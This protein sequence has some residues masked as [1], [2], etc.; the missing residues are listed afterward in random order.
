M[1]AALPPLPATRALPAP[2]RRRRRLRAFSVL[3]LLF[4][5]LVYGASLGAAALYHVVVTV[6][7]ELPA[8]LSQ[9]LQYEPNR[10][11]VVLSSDGEEI[12]AFSIENRRMV[13]L[14]RMPPH[15]VAAFISAEDGRFF[16]HKG[17]DLMGIGRA[18]VRNFRE[19]GAIRQGGSTIT[20]QII[21]QTLLAA[22]E[23]IGD[24]DLTDEE[25]AHLAKL[26][27]YRRKMKEVILAVR[28]E[29]ELTKAEILSI[30]LN[31]I[32][33]GNGAYGVGAAART[34]FGKEIEDVTVAEAAMLAGLVASPSKYAPHRNMELAR[35]RQRYVLGRLR[36]DQYISDAELEAALAEPIALVGES[37]LNHLA[38]PYFVEHI[39]KTATARYGNRDLFKGGL[40]F[41]STLDTRVQAAA[42][43]ALRRGLES[44]E[45]R[46]G[47]RG[48]IGSVPADKRGA[49]TDGPAHP[50][51]GPS[52]DTTALADRVLP[53][54]TY[55]AMVVELPR[56]GAGV[57]VD[58]GPQRLPLAEA[59]AREVRAWR[60]APPKPPAGRPPWYVPPGWTPQTIRLGDLLPVRLA[61]GG[62]AAVLAQ[63]PQLQGG[64]VVLEPS[65]GR[66]L[67]MVGGYDWTESQFD[68]VTQARRQVGSSIKPFIYAAALEAG[69]T[70]VDRMHDGPY[71]VTTATGVW[72]PANYADRYMGSVTLMTA[73]A[74]SLNT[75][76]V[77]LSVQVGIDRLIEI[78]R[79]FGVRSQIP[80]HISI[81]LGTP[82]LTPLEIA[83]GYAGIA[84]GGRRVTP[85][86]F[87]LVTTTGGNVVEDLR[88]APPGPQVLSPEVAYVTT[89]MMKGVISR[90][91][92]RFATQLGRPIAGKTGTSANYR[93]V[94]F[95]GYT[96]DLL[97]TVWV[98]RDDSTPIGD[99]ITGGGIAVPIWLELMQKAH[100][101]TP[102]RDFPVPPNVSFARVEPWSGEVAP[103]WLDA[104]WM[105]FVR[106]TFPRSFLAAPPVRSF[107][108]LWL[109]PTPPP[110]PGAAR[111]T[112]LRCL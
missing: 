100:P 17:F 61:E 31:H 44:L 55:G 78:L 20:Q 10:K 107:D 58:L 97:A 11:S 108:E 80:R 88:E 71:S 24:L 74:F 76:S 86:F 83:A 77:Q 111:C 46:L 98:G 50:L 72:T 7:A 5:L 87:D 66:V 18:A 21:K 106:G 16:S 109:A 60:T 22:E 84:N 36:K 37:Q 6:N 104:P 2:R 34:Y 53:E 29:R 95:T 82:D 99:K 26:L 9:L 30:Y 85:R 67:A 38:S 65:T 75:I 63:R 15:V 62:K 12:G 101:R 73:L 32:Y 39:R 42:E 96:T 68:R 35:D 89:S 47:F 103:A 40:K 91:T 92:A 102:V 81:S 48:P 112:S 23:A 41:Y 3:R 14:E 43:N 94:W 28:L 57:I 27:K 105:A 25:Y 51:T 4:L 90:G 93:D 110:P 70:P 69:R 8:D 59:D 54:Q 56:T 52:G 79:G 45:R 64:M 33:L 1:S 13:A 49:W 19:G